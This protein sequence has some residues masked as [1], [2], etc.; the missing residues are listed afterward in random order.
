M[1]IL[2]LVNDE[3]VMKKSN[4]SVSRSFLIIIFDPTLEIEINWSMLPKGNKNK[5]KMANNNFEI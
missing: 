1:H 2:I 5:F 3:N 4:F